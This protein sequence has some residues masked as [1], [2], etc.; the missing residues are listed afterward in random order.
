[1]G[2]ERLLQSLSRETEAERPQNVTTAF[3]IA[4]SRLLEARSLAHKGLPLPHC[5]QDILPSNP[6]KNFSYLTLLAMQHYRLTFQSRLLVWTA[7]EIDPYHV[8]SFFDPYCVQGGQNV[9]TS[10]WPPLHGLSGPCTAGLKHCIFTLQAYCFSNHSRI[11]PP[12][13]S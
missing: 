11:R 2:A 8:P 12:C 1:M 4:L 6:R 13:S 5:M 9:G 3:L 7:Y 10:H